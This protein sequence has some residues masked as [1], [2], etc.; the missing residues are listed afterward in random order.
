MT[1]TPLRL[2]LAPPRAVRPREGEPEHEGRREDDEHRPLPEPERLELFARVRLPVLARV[3]ARRLPERLVR[4][5][6][7]PVDAPRDRQQTRRQ[8]QRQQR[9]RQRPTR[10]PRLPPRIGLTLDFTQPAPE[11]LT[12]LVNGA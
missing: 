8:R 2:A 3:A 6:V 7:N 4:K 9:P 10:P 12:R 5:V 11:Q 1:H